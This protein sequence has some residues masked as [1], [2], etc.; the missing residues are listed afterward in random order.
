[1]H[2]TSGRMRYFP[3]QIW[4]Y[5]LVALLPCVGHLAFAGT[6]DTAQLANDLRRLSASF[7]GR[8][9][10]CARLGEQSACVRGGERFPLQSVMKLVVAVAALD[11]VDRSQLR[12]DDDIVVRR[13][14]LSI[15][16]QPLARLVT[17]GGYR[18]TVRD[19]LFRAVVASDSAATDILIAR[20]GGAAEIQALLNHRGLSG[21]RIDRDERHLQSESVGLTWQPDYVDAAL[22]RKAVDAVPRDRRQAAF[23]AQLS[24]PRDTATPA[25]MTAL[26]AGLADGRLL[27]RDATRHLLEV[28]DQTTTFPDRLKAGLPPG[29]TIGHKTGTGLDWQGVNAA[30]NDVGLLHAPDGGTLAVAAFIS[31]SRR[32]AQDQAG[33]I[34]TAARLVTAAYRPS[35]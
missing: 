2:F 31:G 13:D 19:L 18:T 34:A 4:F 30:T 3:R 21:I 24:D 12:L 10:I 25:A 14:D 15:G 6:L 27:S 16:V 35:P 32:S 7:D 1:M 5:L 23:D 29:W 11:A 17:P 26:L 9:G 28:M 33:L 22:F 20:L 8:V